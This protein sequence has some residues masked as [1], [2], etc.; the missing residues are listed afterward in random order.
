MSFD[1]KVKKEGHRRLTAFSA[2]VLLALW[3]LLIVRTCPSLGPAEELTI[4][5]V[6]PWSLSDETNGDAE[7]NLAVNAA[8]PDEIVASAE[9]PDPAG[10]KYLPLFISSDGGKNWALTAGLIPKGEQDALCDTTLRFGTKTNALY[11]A[12]LSRKTEAS[13]GLDLFQVDGSA[14]ALSARELCFRRGSYPPGYP[15]QPYVE[16]ATEV[17]AGKVMDHL[18]IGNNDSVSVQHVQSATVDFTS[19]RRPP[20]DHVV[21][22]SAYEGDESS[23]RPAVHSQG[24][25]YVAFGG[26]VFVSGTLQDM[27]IKVVRDD[28]WGSGTPPFHDLGASGLGIVVKDHVPYI[29]R[30]LGPQKLSLGLAIAADPTDA[31][32]VY[33]VYGSL[34][35][36][37][38]YTLHVARSNNGGRSWEPDV[39]AV[40]SATNPGIAVASNGQIGLLF[41]KYCPGTDR[42]ETHLLR[43]RNFNPS[44][45]VDTILANLPA[46]ILGASLP[47]IGDYTSLLAVGE[48]FYGIFSGYNVPERKNFPHG[49][50]FQR[51][52]SFSACQLLGVTGKIIDPSVDPFFFR[53]SGPIPGDCCLS[54]P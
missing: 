45:T 9:T 2:S 53:V 19:S 17:T 51:R 28:K 6:I 31:D 13:S 36:N 16:V 20:I 39:Y 35:R 43:T 41:Q 24:R 49:V 21:V 7:P 32:K 29:Q 42:L 8:N 44:N 27:T 38:V 14:T 5:D 12:A 25:V 15:D 30:N 11:V 26:F 54:L 37:E 4:V 3:G 23:V 52:H 34:D 33:L 46:R 1:S 10:S 18:F 50:V 22:E 47:T 48:V 40:P